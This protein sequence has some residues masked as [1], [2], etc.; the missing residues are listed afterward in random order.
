M[1]SSNE[2]SLTSDFFEALYQENPDPWQFETSAYEAEKYA[3]T[4]NSLPRASYQSGFEIGGSIGILTEK[5]AQRCH[6]LLSVDV[7]NIAQEQ[8]VKRCHYLSNVHFQMMSIPQD[9]PKDHF[10]LILVS[11]VGYYWSWSD[12]RKAQNLILTQLQSKGHLLLVHWIVDA[13][14]LPLTGDQVHDAFLE[15]VP[16]PLRHVASL[17]KREYRLD[18]FEKDPS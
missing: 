2:Q 5:L 11:E 15:L 12:L 17:K 7:S 9:F 3:T 13:K 14:V 18:L 8:A 16:T 1:S 4:L 6:S 10:D